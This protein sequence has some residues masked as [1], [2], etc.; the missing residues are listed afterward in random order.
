MYQ[1]DHTHLA[2]RWESFWQEFLDRLKGGKE[3]KLE[4]QVIACLRCSAAPFLKDRKEHSMIQYLQ[5]GYF[6]ELLSMDFQSMDWKKL[7]NSLTACCLTLPGSGEATLHH[8][9]VP[10][11]WSLSV[12]AAVTSER[13]SYCVAILLPTAQCLVIIDKSYYN[14]LLKWKHVMIFL[15]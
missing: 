8:P 4:W 3:L 5:M 7:L 13:S 2:G 6:S 14:M 11:T 10:S 1:P 9:T 15:K 12:Q